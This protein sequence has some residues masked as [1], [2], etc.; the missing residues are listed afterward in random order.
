MKKNK[1]LLVGLCLVGI[2]STA[3]RAA[4]APRWYVGGSRGLTRTHYSMNDAALF[5]YDPIPEIENH[6]N[7]WKIFGGYH[8]SPNWG[9]ELA[10]I[11]LGTASFSGPSGGINARDT[12]S[13]RAT[14]LV[15]VG[16]LPLKNN[17][18][19]FGKVGLYSSLSTYRCVEYCGGIADDDR[20]TTRE[21]AGVGMQYD[22]THNL[23]LRAEYE[24]FSRIPTA[25][26]INGNTINIESNY[27]LWSIGGI[28]QF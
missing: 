13:V 8:F 6:D 14:N 28:Y 22:F 25:A 4:Y 5:D 16:T 10:Y 15:G 24:H 18:S 9:V 3:A 11:H 27:D 20:G 21:S 7:A 2:G 1:I 26:V 12:F 17:F 23:G 19:I